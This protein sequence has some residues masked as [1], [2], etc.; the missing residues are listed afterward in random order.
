[1]ACS[2]VRYRYRLRVS[3]GQAVAL[4][5][6]FD[7]CRF[8]WNQALGRWGDLWRDEGLRLSCADADKEL[9]DWRSRFDWLAAQP[10]VPH[11]Q[12]LRDFYLAVSAFFDKANPAG[13][14]GRKTRKAGYATARWTRNG[15]A[16]SGTGLG[17]AGDDRLEVA[18]AGR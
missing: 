11:Q 3:P 10:S 12:V 8:V 1:M 6:V 13:R 9:T 18:T 14:P 16:V 5:D 7:T 15:F 4:Q 17:Q 2:E